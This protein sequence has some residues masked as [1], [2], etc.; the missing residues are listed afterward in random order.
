[1][2]VRRGARTYRFDRLFDVWRQ[3]ASHDGQRWALS[4][5]GPDGDAELT[6]SA[7]GRPMVCLGYDNPDGHRSYC[8]N[9]KLARTTLT[10]RPADG[11]SFSCVSEH[12]GALEFLSRTPDPRF[13]HVV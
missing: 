8:L 5:L 10:V 1:M 3:R 13:L 11:A 2:V 6:M 9:S 7:E 12:G 4:L